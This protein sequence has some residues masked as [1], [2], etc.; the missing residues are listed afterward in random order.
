MGSQKPPRSYLGTPCSS[1]S[2]A[3][4]QPAFTPSDSPTKASHNLSILMLLLQGYA[5]SDFC[6]TLI[7]CKKQ[8]VCSC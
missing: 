7:R 3:D 4:R 6:H 5:F 1:V 2:P 8:F